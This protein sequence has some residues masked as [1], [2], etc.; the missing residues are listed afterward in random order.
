MKDGY[1]LEGNLIKVAWATSKGI[2]KDRILKQYWN[3]EVGCAYVPWPELKPFVNFVNWAEGGLVD[4]ES[5][6]PEYFS[7]Y[8]QQTRPNVSTTI[9]RN[10]NDG[11]YTEPQNMYCL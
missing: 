4:E 7:I 6:P 1:R 3:V 10:K 11:T 8:K 5:I 9:D 2:N